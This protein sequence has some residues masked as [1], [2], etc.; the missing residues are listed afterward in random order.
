MVYGAS[1]N[2]TYDAAEHKKELT[3]I[4]NELTEIKK[5]IRSLKT[6]IQSNV[7]KG[8]K[9][10]PSINAKTNIKG[11]PSM[12]KADA[13]LVLVEFSD[14]QCPYCARHSLKTM[15]RIKKDYVD[16]GKIRYVFK[17]MPLAFHKNAKKAAEAAHCAGE[18]G[19][20]WEMHDLLFANQQKLS[21]DDLKGYAEELGLKKSSFEKCLDSGRYA[22]EVKSDLKAAKA[23]GIK[24]TPSFIIGRVEKNGMVDG[25]ILRGAQPYGAFKAAIDEILEDKKKK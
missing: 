10:P 9:K 16:T 20:Y 13:P 6:L 14:Y 15:P 17:D 12:G 1:G 3:E 5:E 7:A 23:A 19:K 2:N 4:K 21:I 25:R 24:G 11:D 8:V 22:E 18:K